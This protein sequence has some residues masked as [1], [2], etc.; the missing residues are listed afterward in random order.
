MPLVVS[1]VSTHATKVSA[2]SSNLKAPAYA[3]AFFLVQWLLGPTELSHKV[4]LARFTHKVGE[5][6]I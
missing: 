4:G 3:G 1:S 2:L 6:F 5:T